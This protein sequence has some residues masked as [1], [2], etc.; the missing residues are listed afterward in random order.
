M[1]IECDV[2]KCRHNDFDDD[3]TLGCCVLEIV[4]IVNGECND[5]TDRKNQ[6]ELHSKGT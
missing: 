1:K 6:N 3:P 5:R 2:V 4:H